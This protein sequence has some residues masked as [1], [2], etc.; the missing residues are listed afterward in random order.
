MNT[1]AYQELIGILQDGEQV[2]GIVFGAWGWGGA[3]RPGEDWKLE[4]DEPEDPPV[5]FAV[6][7][8]VL[9]L[10]EAKPYMRGWSFFGGYGAPDC[11][12]TYI[13]T[14][15]RVIWVTQYDGS[16]QLD[17][18]PRHPENTMPDMPGG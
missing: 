15:R 17:D 1:S 10:D 16:T 18:A 2:E 6:R 13:W 9:S 5:P 8:S 7:G 14:D 3:P 11:Y 4:L 12:A